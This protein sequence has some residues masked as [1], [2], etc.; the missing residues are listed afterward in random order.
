MRKESGS[1]VMLWVRVLSH[2]SYRLAAGDI[3]ASFLRMFC[4]ASVSTDF[5]FRSTGACLASRSCA[6]IGVAHMASSAVKAIDLIVLFSLIVLYLGATWAKLMMVL[7][8]AC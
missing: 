4:S 5:I 2:E 7:K 6:A 8:F 1:A 3:A